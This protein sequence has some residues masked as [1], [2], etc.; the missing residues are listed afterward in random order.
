MCK[1]YQ[2]ADG[3]F[4]IRSVGSKVLKSKLSSRAFLE[5]IVTAVKWRKGI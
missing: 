1:W 4:L 3:Q 5:N 2:T